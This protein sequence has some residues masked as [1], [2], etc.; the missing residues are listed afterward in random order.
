MDYT[1]QLT[2][3]EG[4]RLINKFCK[5][6]T[7]RC[8]ACPMRIIPDGCWF[9]HYPRGWRMSNFLEKCNETIEWAKNEEA[10]GPKDKQEV[11]DEV[12]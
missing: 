7:R 8:G 4:I 6:R 12:D 5:S 2:F 10:S 3:E 1:K 11:Q 9:K